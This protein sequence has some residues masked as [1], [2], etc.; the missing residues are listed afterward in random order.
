MIFMLQ[1]CGPHIEQK[2]ATFIESLG[3]V[4][5]WNSLAV[6][7]SRPRL[8]WS[9]QRNSKRAFDS[10]LSRMAAPGCPLARS[11]AW[12]AIL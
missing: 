12:A 2:C 4:S 11:A 7:G 8:N 1:K 10:A 5:S 3:R 9:S 6:S